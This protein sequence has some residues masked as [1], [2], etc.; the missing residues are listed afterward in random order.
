MIY[1]GKKVIQCSKS[2]YTKNP[3]QAYLE[4]ESLDDIKYSF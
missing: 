3:C 4:Q 2:L 1:R